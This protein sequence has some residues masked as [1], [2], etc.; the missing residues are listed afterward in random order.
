MATLHTE[1]GSLK[2]PSFRWRGKSFS[3]ST[4]S[5]C[6]IYIKTRKIR[7]AKIIAEEALSFPPSSPHHTS[8]MP[9]DRQKGWG[10]D[11]LWKDTH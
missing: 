6:H 7:P 8:V 5:F 3:L 2:I 4:D 10:G 1:K 11:G 9:S